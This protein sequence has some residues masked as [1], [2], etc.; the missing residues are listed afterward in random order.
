MSVNRMRRIFLLIFSLAVIP[1]SVLPAAALWGLGEDRSLVTVNDDRLTE[2]DFRGWWKEWR[3]EGMVPPADPDAYIDW[4]LLWRE[5][6]KMQLYEKD[7]YRRKVDVFLKVWSLMQ[8]KQEEVDGKIPEPG[9]ADLWQAYVNEYAP[10][11]RLRM[12]R[13]PDE[14]K[15]AAMRGALD[16]GQSLRD[17]SNAAGG[18]S[19]ADYMEDSGWLRPFKIPAVLRTAVLEVPVGEKIGPVYWE[20][21]WYFLEVLGREEAKEDD[22]LK[23]RDVLTRKWQ[24]QWS[25]TLTTELVEK[26]KAKYRVSVNAKVIQAIG[27]V[28]TS[29]E[30][31][32]W[33]AITF[34]D[35]VITV[36]ALEPLLRKEQATKPSEAFTVLREQVVNDLLA[37]TLTGL[38]AMDR[39]YENR[40]PFKSTFEFYKQHRLI[41]ELESELFWSQANV[42]EEEIRD[43]YLRHPDRYSAGGRVELTHVETREKELAHKV[44]KKIANGEDFY[45]AMKP[46][47]PGEI[48][49]ETI[50][51]N[52]LD[53]KIR[54]HLDDMAPGE[55]KRW[56]EAD[57][58]IVFI[59]LVRRE[60]SSPRPLDEVSGTIREAL[61]QKRFEEL[62][63]RFVQELRK[64]S[65]IKTNDKAWESLHHQLLK[66]EG[67]DAKS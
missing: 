38:E 19:V 22:F 7:S 55:V 45:A 47:V 26:A 48:H 57:G 20:A 58:E 9:R 4:T 39:H 46:L 44:W 52:H 28:P 29:P 27:P 42:T 32:E 2:A 3:E 62:R 25:A 54:K 49:P 33:P 31:A 34:G 59:K 5:A 60:L 30:M 65:T 16:R 18:V 35:E 14:K 37:Q 23:Y 56:E 21:A 10:K 40:P 36:S 24:K 15:V 8:L 43:E 64:R 13:I 53:E 63:T 17:A 6:E 50:P 41:K 12:V 66:E 61:R 51:L 11:V 67:A 1:L